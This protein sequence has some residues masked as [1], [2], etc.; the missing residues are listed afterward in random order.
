VEGWVEA[1]EVE[2]TSRI[3]P[4]VTVPRKLIAAVAPF[5]ASLSWGPK[6]S[7]TLSNVTDQ[8]GKENEMRWRRFGSSSQFSSTTSGQSV[9]WGSK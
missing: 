6:G 1:P 2:S 9:L 7:V 8:S 5:H 4:Q 3:L